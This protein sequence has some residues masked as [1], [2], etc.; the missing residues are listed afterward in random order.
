MEASEFVLNTT[1]AT[2]VFTGVVAALFLPSLSKP[3]VTRWESISGWWL[4]TAFFL[5]L[6]AVTFNPTRYSTAPLILWILA[7]TYLFVVVTVAIHM[8]ELFIK[9]RSIPRV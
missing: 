2:A 4:L 9:W 6:L 3:K 5:G 7:L 8:V 1:T